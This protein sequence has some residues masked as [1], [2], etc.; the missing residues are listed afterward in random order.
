[1]HEEIKKLFQDNAQEIGLSKEQVEKI[2][3]LI[4]RNELMITKSFDFY[5]WEEDIKYYAAKHFGL[6]DIND[7]DML[8]ML[9]RFHGKQDSELSHWDNIHGVL[10]WFIMERI[11]E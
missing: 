8:I 2:Y 4:L 1:M 6:V 7:D 9:N 10:D 5:Y 11:K 3:Q